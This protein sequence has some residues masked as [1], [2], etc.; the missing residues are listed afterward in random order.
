MKER[1]PFSLNRLDV[2]CVLFIIMNNF[3]VNSFL[4]NSVFYHLLTRLVWWALKIILIFLLLV[5]SCGYLCVGNLQVSA[6][7]RKSRGIRSPGT[8]V[9]SHSNIESHWTWVLGSKLGKSTSMLLTVYHLSTVL[10][11]IL[12]GVFILKISLLVSSVMN[13]IKWDMDT[14]NP[15]LQKAALWT[16]LGMGSWILQF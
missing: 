1:H 15:D 6:E 2:L 3:K 12:V 13:T 4:Q 9:I 10:M 16:K 5:P 11:H 8:G 14:T 7:T